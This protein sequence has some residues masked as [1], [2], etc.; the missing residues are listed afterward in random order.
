MMP[1]R[2]QHV[3]RSVNGDVKRMHLS[4]WHEHHNTSTEQ[5]AVLF[6]VRDTPTLVALGK[7]REQAYTKHGDHQPVTGDF[8]PRLLQQ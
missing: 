7:Y 1:T 8:D 2:L 5:R 3:E 6:S 4:F